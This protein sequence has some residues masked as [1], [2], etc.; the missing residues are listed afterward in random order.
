MGK[1]ADIV[2]IIWIS[3]IA[4]SYRSFF[5]Q[6]IF[7]KKRLILCIYYDTICIDIHD[8]YIQL[9]RMGLFTTYPFCFYQDKQIFE[10]IVR[11][12]VKHD[13]NNMVWYSITDDKYGYNN[14]SVRPVYPFQRQ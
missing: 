14:N 8:S 11:K 3:G 10:Y 13:E 12:V 2:E 9:E 5:V 7:N 1:A 4:E 6:C